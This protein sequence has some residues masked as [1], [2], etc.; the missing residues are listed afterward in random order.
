MEDL[1]LYSTGCPKCEVLKKKLVAKN[2]RYNEENSREKMLEL[3]LTEVPVLSVNGDL[4]SFGE[5]VKWINS[6][7]D[8]TT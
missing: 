4:K 5:A 8:E 2:I 6:T 3:G 7:G 1:I